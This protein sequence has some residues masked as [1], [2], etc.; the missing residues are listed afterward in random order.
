[1]GYTPYTLLDAILVGCPTDVKG[2]PGE[3]VTIVKT[4]AIIYS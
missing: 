2:L 1:M 4:A 3:S